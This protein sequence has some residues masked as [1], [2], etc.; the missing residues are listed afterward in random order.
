MNNEK[1]HVM[2]NRCSL[3]RRDNILL[4]VCFSVR[5]LA[6]RVAAPLQVRARFIALLAIIL[7]ALGGCQ[8]YDD[9][10]LW[11]ELNSQAGRLAAME[12]WQTAMNGNIAALQELVNAVQARRYITGV[13]EY[14]APEPGGY[15][16]SFNTGDPVTI[17]NGAAGDKGNTGSKG[18]AGDNPQIGVAEY[19]VGSGAYYW[20]LNGE[21]IEPNGQKLPVTGAE[22]D[23]GQPGAPGTPGVT[24][25]LRINA[26]TNYWQVCTTGACDVQADA[27]WENV[28]G[29]DGQ[30][31]KASGE[32]NPQGDVVFA[33][34]GVDA[35]NADYVEFTLADGVTKIQV[36]K[37]RPL[38]IILLP[39]ATFT[40]G[41][42]RALGF[43]VTGPVQS[44][45][46]VGV[47][48]GWTVTPDLA[49]QVIT[50]T[51]PVTDADGYTAAGTVTLLVSDGAARTIAKP[52][53]LECPEYVLGI[54]FTQPKRF[55][56]SA[57]RYVAYT[58][59]GNATTV[60]VEA[61]AG[62]T[63]SVQPAGSAGTFTITAP[64][65]TSRSEA[66]ILVFDAAGKTVIRTLQLVTADILLIWGD[67]ARLPGCDK[68]DFANN[69]TEPQCRSYTSGTNTWYYYNWA[70]VH[71]YANRLCPSPWY[72]PDR[73]EIYDE[74]FAHAVSVETMINAWGYGGYVDGGS[75][76]HD[77]TEAYY[78]SSTENNTNTAYYLTYNSSEKNLRTTNKYYGY[79]V[80]CVK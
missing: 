29:S 26:A 55:N 44:I 79:Q 61:P 37:Y 15:F 21:F 64:A 31:V 28:L 42:V 59:T 78:W 18:A 22:G 13:S 50:V 60:K 5:R 62:W 76:V 63:V 11:N 54:N 36:P 75:I 68:A 19:P 77:E 52:L 49:A 6:G 30:P 74:F 39:P 47:P 32:S 16:I 41:E 24:P 70:Y 58:T 14:A 72:V 12:A 73:D 53:A 69:D 71:A 7:I 66:V 9:S 20:T 56:Y 67:P 34:G 40:N 33:P 25:K 8:K 65:T 1:C 17:T 51:A 35:S 46:A 45:T 4:T 80:R 43:D 38:N 10:A 23:N 48:H 57:T 27:G 3:S 2:K